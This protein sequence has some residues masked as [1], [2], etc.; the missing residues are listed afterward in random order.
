MVVERVF[1]LEQLDEKKATGLLDPRV[2][3]GGNKLSAVMNPQTTMWTF[4]LEHGL[5]PLPLRNRYT[6]YKS[7]YRHAEDYFSTKN[8]KIKEVIY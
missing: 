3:K 7:L 4:K 1:V 5:V 8:I 2:Y 6:D